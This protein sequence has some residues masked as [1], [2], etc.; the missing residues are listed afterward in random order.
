MS[1]DR[2]VCDLYTGVR[3]FDKQ[4]SIRHVRIGDVGYRE[5][6]RLIQSLLA[7]KD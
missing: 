2:A 7:E 5:T 3:Q 4:G 6:K 1:S